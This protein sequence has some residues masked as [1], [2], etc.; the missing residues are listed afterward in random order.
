MKSVLT[1]LF[2]RWAL[3]SSWALRMPASS[4]C[5]SLQLRDSAA[6]SCRSFSTR[7]L[8]AWASL[9]AWLALLLSSSSAL[10]LWLRL[11]SLQP[12]PWKDTCGAHGQDNR[13]TYK[14]FGSQAKAAQSSF[15]LIW[16]RISHC[17]LKHLYYLT[18]RRKFI[19]QQPALTCSEQLA[20][21]SHR[22]LLPSIFILW[23]NE[24]PSLDF[25][26]EKRPLKKRKSNWSSNESRLWNLVMRND[27][28]QSVVPLMFAM[29]FENI[30]ILIKKT[31]NGWKIKDSRKGL[32]TCVDHSASIEQHFSIDVEFFN[33]LK[34]HRKDWMFQWRPPVLKK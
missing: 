20:H 10:A 26:E 22:L 2:C 25:H 3:R 14:K 32:W 7:R 30:Q 12:Q 24:N 1:A 17:A 19:V 6:L 11:N 13:S 27:F 15:G 8:S 16:I 9:C 28:C 21:K 34:F 29:S 31:A 23:R 33:S 18:M 5:F 4:W